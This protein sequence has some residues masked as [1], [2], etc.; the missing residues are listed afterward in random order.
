MDVSNKRL[1]MSEKKITRESMSS[2]KC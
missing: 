2:I 1:L